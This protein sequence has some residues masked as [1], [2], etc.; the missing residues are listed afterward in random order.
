M[1]LNV[2]EHRY[3][4]HVQSILER[5]QSLTLIVAQI[6]AEIEEISG[7]VQ[8]LNHDVETFITDR[9]SHAD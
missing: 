9:R 8:D 6:E 1:D 4:E 2:F 3:R 7:A 5:L